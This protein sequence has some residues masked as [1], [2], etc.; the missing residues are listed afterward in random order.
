MHYQDNNTEHHK[1]NCPLYEQTLPN[2][3]GKTGNGINKNNYSPSNYNSQQLPRKS[4][5]N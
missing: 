4:C 3:W 1:V 2:S 5:S